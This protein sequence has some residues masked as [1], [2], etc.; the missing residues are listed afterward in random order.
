[1]KRSAF[2]L[3]L[4]TACAFGSG[5]CSGGDGGTKA[6]MCLEACSVASDC[7]MTGTTVDDWK[8]EKHRCVYNLCSSDEDC[9]ARMSGWIT[10]CTESGGECAQGNVCVSIGVGGLCA[11]ESRPGVLECTDMQMEEIQ[12]PAIDGSGDVTV[13]G[14]SGYSCEGSLCVAPDCQDDS[15]CTAPTPL[16]DEGDCVQCKSDDD[17]SDGDL[18]RCNRKGMCGCADDSECTGGLSRCTSSGVCG[19]AD[20]SECTSSTKD[21]CYDGSCGCSSADVCTNETQGANTTWVC[22]RS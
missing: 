10:E 20:D 6:R 4:F 2:A 19:C 13:C 12:M 5:A 7:V 3:A 9:T 11:L 18:T 21:R 14:I 22:E 1:M 8:C 15:D 16:C 17:C